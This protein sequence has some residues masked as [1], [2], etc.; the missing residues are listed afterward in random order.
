MLKFKNSKNKGKEF[1]Y[2]VFGQKKLALKIDDLI[3][4]IR[5]N[6]ENK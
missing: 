6:F 2:E 4:N 1:C 3:K 5:V